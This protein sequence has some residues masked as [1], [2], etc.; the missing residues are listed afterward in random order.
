MLRFIVAVL[1]L[2][3]IGFYVWSQGG[4]E[5]MVG[6]HP[7]GDREPARLGQQVAPEGIKILPPKMV[8]A[9]VPNKAPQTAGTCIEIGPFPSDQMGQAQTVLQKAIPAERWITLK[10]ETPAIWMVHMA[11]SSDTALQKKQM[12]ILQRL[13]VPFEEVSDVARAGNGLSLGK[14]NTRTAA[15]KALAGFSSQ[16]LRKLKVTE[17]IPAS[18]THTLRAD[19]IHAATQAQLRALEGHESLGGRN[20]KAC[21]VP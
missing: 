16:G 12:D 9:S 13:E 19:G 3:N 21:D 15:E 11:P 2:A 17:F 1:L 14:F 20:F 8:A 10:T 5:G 18:F 6:L 7:N 4:F